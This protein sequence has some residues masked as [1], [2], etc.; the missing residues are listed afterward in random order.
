MAISLADIKRSTLGPPRTVLYGVPGIGKST[1]ASL[2]PSPI[3]LPIEDGLGQLDVPAFPR[4]ATYAQVIECVELLLREQHSYETFVIDTLDKLEPLIW[5]HVCEVNG[6]RSI[7]DFGYGKG[8]SAAAAVWRELLAGFDALRDKGM[9]VHPIAH[10]Q[11][12]RFDP[13]DSDSYDRYQLRLHKLA[14]ALVCDW[15]DNVLFIKDNVVA[16]AAGKNDERKRGVNDGKRVVY[17]TEKAAWRAKNRYGL[18][19]ALFINEPGDLWRQLLTKI[20][21]KAAAVATA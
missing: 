17:T 18:P 5:Q 20:Q 7:E 14:D 15:A 6:K 8:F 16:I 19:P 1:E 13:P 3:F 11:V 2:A 4:P 21:P 9:I 10:S 12:A